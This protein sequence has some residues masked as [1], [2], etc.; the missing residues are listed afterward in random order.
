LEVE[1]CFYLVILVSILPEGRN[2]FHVENTTSLEG[3]ETCLDH[4]QKNVS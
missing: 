4:K 2:A 3:P 1:S